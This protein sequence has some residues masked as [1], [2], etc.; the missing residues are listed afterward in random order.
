MQ[1]DCQEKLWNAV[2]SPLLS[3]APRCV[4]LR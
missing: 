1:S 2:R 3:D 4:N